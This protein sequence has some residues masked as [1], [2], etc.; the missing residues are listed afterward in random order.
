MVADGHDV[1]DRPAGQ[2]VDVLRALAGDVDARLGH[3]PDRVGIQPCGLDAGRI[4]LDRVAL[5]MPRPAL[6]HLAAA[7]VARAKKQNRRFH[8]RPSEYRR[9]KNSF[10]TI[11][12]AAKLLGILRQL[13]HVLKTAAQAFEQLLMESIPRGSKLVVVP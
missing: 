2:L 6:G 10:T 12:A 7:G 5:Q 3:H 9:Q 13:R 8:I 4:G 11:R 1:I